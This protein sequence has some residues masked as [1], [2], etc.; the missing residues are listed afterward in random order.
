MEND[1]YT[2][3]PVVT[4]TETRYVVGYITRS[5]LRQALGTW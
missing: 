4:S 5:E 3:W 1:S 2:G